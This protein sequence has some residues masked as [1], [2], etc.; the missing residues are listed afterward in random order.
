MNFKPTA[1]EIS[2]IWQF[3]ISNQAHVCF[4]EHWISH[5]E[6]EDLKKVLQYSK[7]A[8]NQI[9]HQG[10][11]LYSKAGFP[12][13][14]G[15]S[16]DQDVM[17]G[18]PRLMSDKLTLIILHILSEYG[19]YTYGLALGKIETPEVLSFMKSTLN[20]AADLYQLITELVRK[21]GYEH[22]PVFIPAPKQA[23]FVNNQSFLAGWWGEQRPLNAVEIDNLIFSLRG[24]ILAKTLFMVFSQIAKDPKL[25]RFCLRGAE[26][27]GKR[28]EKIQSLNTS[29]HIPFQ[30][31]YET[32]ITD[33]TISPF[34]DRL[35]MF[36]AIALSQIAIARYG[37]ALSFVM[38][39][40][41][42]TMFARYIIETGTF[43][44]DGLSLMIDKKWFEQPPLG[45]DRNKLSERE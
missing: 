6:D 44:D 42:S 37:N 18:V 17:S 27:T 12:S 13:P 45:I 25:Q 9:V 16:V 11:E 35:I 40:D 36:E 7:D 22:Q 21:K 39:R 23:D 19:V 1:G 10:L 2:N 15:F 20:N 31:T 8:A 38:R 14:I 4:L 3:I 32:E 30:A 26:I 33:S 43:L 41:L 34:T 5:A 29:E 28:V 24:V